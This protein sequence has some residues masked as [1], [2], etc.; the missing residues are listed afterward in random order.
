MVSHGCVALEAGT[1]A[2][3]GDRVHFGL[4]RLD[5]LNLWM[6]D[7]MVVIDTSRPRVLSTP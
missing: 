3:V 1:R 5:T 6:A 2:H 7:A 4:I